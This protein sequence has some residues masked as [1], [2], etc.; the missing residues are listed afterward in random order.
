MIS[1][2]AKNLQYA[3]KLLGGAPRQIELAAVNAINR[4]ATKMKTQVSKT[5]R[6]NYTIK[7]GN[8]KESL[9]LE[10]ASRSKLQGVIVSRGRPPLLTA[11]DL[12]RYKK[13]PMKAKIRKDGNIKPVKGVF[14]GASRTGYIGAMQRTQHAR[15]PLRIPRGPSVPQMFGSEA[16]IDELTPMAEQALNERFL[17]EVEFRFNKTIQ[18]KL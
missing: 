10:R 1:I 3:Q 17:H 4:T 11:F 8:I 14:L 15:Y 2:E 13:G 18:E 7:A 16:V 9:Q 6:K 5:I 12:R